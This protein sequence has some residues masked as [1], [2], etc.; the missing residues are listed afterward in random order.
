MKKLV[1]ILMIMF[2]GLVIFKDVYAQEQKF[3]Y[4]D[5]IRVFEAYNKTEKYNT[6]LEEDKNAKTKEREKSIEEIKKLQDKL[7]I[8]AK[9]E[10][11]KTQ[12]EIEDKIKSLQQFE[13]QAA[14]DLRKEYATMMEE[15]LKEINKVIKDYAVKNNFT[16]VFKDAALAY[17][18]Q[19]L[20]ISDQIIKILN[21]IK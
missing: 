3:A 18:V 16:F 10:K 17:G 11:E 19:T 4:V 13:N 9:E 7:S 2:F 1:I 14:L 21:E 6:K 15:L 12:K 8:V 5:I 20:D